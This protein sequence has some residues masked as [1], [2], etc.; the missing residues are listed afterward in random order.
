M[1]GLE[2]LINKVKL[3]ESTSYSD[4]MFKLKPFLNEYLRITKESRLEQLQTDKTTT[5]TLIKTN[6]ERIQAIRDETQTL[7]DNYDRQIR[8][9]NRFMSEYNDRN[10]EFYLTQIE[11][12]DE[13][14]EDIKDLEEDGFEDR[15]KQLLDFIK[16]YN[17]LIGNM[18]SPPREDWSGMYMDARARGDYETMEYANRQANIDRGVGDRVTS[19]VD[20]ESV[21]NKSS[22]SSSGSSSSPSTVRANSDGKAPPGQSVGTIVKTNGGDYQIT[23]VNK[24]GSYESKKIEKRSYAHGGKITDTGTF[25]TDFHGK[26]S[27]PEWIFNDAQLQKVL[28]S[29]VLSTVNIAIPKIPSLQLAG[30]AGGDT[31]YY[32][33]ELNV[34]TNDFQSFIKDFTSVVENHPNK[35]VMKVKKIGGLK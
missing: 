17:K 1:G 23:K 6:N 11:E 20:I 26:Q 13:L 19:G 5:E 3:M 34:P 14:I 27:D 32:I 8:N 4:R 7:V 35:T 28:K 18:D 24:D 2:D 15:L 12:L 9:L 25:L 21:K 33:D 22:S 30:G 10:E 31:I 29:A 16:E